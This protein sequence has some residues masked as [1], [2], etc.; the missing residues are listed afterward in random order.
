LDQTPSI[1]PLGDSAITLDLG[2]LIDEQLNRK[3]LAIEGRLR[4]RPFPGIKDVIT[5]YS[6]VTVVYD[7]V[8]IRGQV[9]NLEGS[10]YKYVCGLL[11]EVYAEVAMTASLAGDGPGIVQRVPVCYGGEF[12]PDLEETSRIRQMTPED[13]I[14]VHCSTVYRVY[15]VGFL[16]GFPYLGKLDPR[17][18]LA[19]KERPAPVAAGGVGI[20]GHQT[21][22]YPVNSPGGWQIIGRTPIKLFDPAVTPPVKFSIGD[23]VEF[24]PISEGEFRSFCPE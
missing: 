7:P 8:E 9:R 18:Q 1:F 21:G 17:L 13:I 3:A 4:A 5:A 16:P 14:T 22:I 24:Y 15:M 10:I 23:L 6:S 20:A 2:H 11:E 19:R 12:G